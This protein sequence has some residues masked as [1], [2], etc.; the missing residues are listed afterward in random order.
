MNNQTLIFEGHNVEAF[1]LNG[2]VYF[3]PR[4]VAECLGLTKIAV[5]KAILKMNT[6]QVRKLKNSDV[7]NCNIRRLL[8]NA[9][10]NFLTESGVYKLAFQSLKPEAERFTNWVTD[11]VLPQIRKTGGYIPT[12]TPTSV[13]YTDEEIVAQALIIVHKTLELRTKRLADAEAALQQANMQVAQMQPKVDYCDN[14]LSATNLITTTDI[15]KYDY[16]MSAMAL[17]KLLC[18]WGIQ[19]KKGDRYYLYAQYDNMGYIGSKTATWSH[20][21]GSPGTSTHM[22]WTQLGREFIHQQMKQRGYLT[23]AETAQNLANTVCVDGEVS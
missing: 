6:T 5:R 3:N 20:K 15:A 23:T 16:G 4:T 17:N 9:G 7:T 13:P 22:M 21:D 12:A 10:E 8:N 18:A 1:E 19:Y 14:V 2:V 11:V